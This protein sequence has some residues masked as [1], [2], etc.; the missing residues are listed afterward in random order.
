VHLEV[1]HWPNFLVIF[2]LSEMDLFEDG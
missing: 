2:D 1:L